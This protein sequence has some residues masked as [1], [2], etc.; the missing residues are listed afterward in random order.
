VHEGFED[1]PTEHLSYGFC[2]RAGECCTDGPQADPLWAFVSSNLLIVGGVPSA[3]MR[4]ENSVVAELPV[5]NGTT[6]ENHLTDSARQGEPDG[7]VGCV[8]AILPTHD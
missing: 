5:A 6:Q 3:T 1:T 4:K 2:D 7:L 8:R